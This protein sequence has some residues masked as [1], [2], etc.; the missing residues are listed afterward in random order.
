[1]NKL[2]IKPSHSE[3]HLI[4]NKCADSLPPQIFDDISKASHKVFV[5]G[6]GGWPQVTYYCHSVNE[7][8]AY[9]ELPFK[10]THWAYFNEPPQD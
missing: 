8:F 5:W 10:I 1:M 2:T 6:K 9:N 4:W 3:G 7:W